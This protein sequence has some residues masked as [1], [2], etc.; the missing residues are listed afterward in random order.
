MRP[1]LK[2]LALI[3]VACFALTT[4]C[5]CASSAAIRVGKIAISENDYFYW[6]L[7]YKMSQLQNVGGT[8]E[9]GFWDTPVSEGI[10]VADSIKTAAIDQA[11]TF[12]VTDYLFE[13]EG[14]S[15]T[16]E[17]LTDINKEISSA[18]ASSSFASTLKKFGIS[19]SDYTRM[20]YQQKRYYKV[21]AN[22]FGTE[23]LTPVTDEAVRQFY[24]DEYVRVKHI[25][26]KLV[27][28][29]GKALDSAT[30][31]AK[32]TQAQTLLA[33]ALSA[34][35]EDFD[36]M[37]SEYSEDSGKSTYP[38]GYIFNNTMSFPKEFMTASFEMEVG[39]V[40]LVET[41]AGLHILRKE[42]LEPDT[43]LTDTR[44]TQIKA[45]YAQ[46]QFSLLVKE[47][48][49]ELGVTFNEK[50]LNKYNVATITYLS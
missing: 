14:L 4:F 27:D 22:H 38:E 48:R 3:L 5:G 16:S 9:E 36:A 1:T 23:G 6:L 50:I 40:R 26:L 2:C 34:S 44:L 15:F 42:A 25:Q 41:S 24:E 37:I 18:Q 13:Q 45:A 11:V 31:A 32:R 47:K 49:E 46:Q 28:S 30:V 43:Y 12:A 33:E 29:A 20:Y 8:V 35:A 10:T 39:E 7:S 17:E 21:F 19:S